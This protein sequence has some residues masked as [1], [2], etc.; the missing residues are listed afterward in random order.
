[1]KPTAREELDVYY[2]EVRK[3]IRILLE[4]SVRTHESNL[5][6]MERLGVQNEWRDKSKLAY[7]KIQQLLDPSYTPD[8]SPPGT[9]PAGASAGPTA[10]PIPQ[11]P[12]SRGG[13][14][15]PASSGSQSPDP[16]RGSKPRPPAG[17]IRQVL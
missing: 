17:P 2:Q 10:P 8:F 3:K 16:D 11:P 6:M 1:L 14:G 12:S 13:A 9:S 4:K 7:A 15:E 5:L